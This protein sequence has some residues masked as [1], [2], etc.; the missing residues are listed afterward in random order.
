MDIDEVFKEVTGE[1]GPMQKKL[2]F[3]L[4]SMQ[5]FTA[6]QMVHMVFVGAEPEVLCITA[7][8][9]VKRGC[10]ELGEVCKEYRAE[11]TFTSIATQVCIVK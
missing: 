10:G 5:A 7:D 4:A 9:V 6:F 8:N 11:S 1:C 2:L 3:M